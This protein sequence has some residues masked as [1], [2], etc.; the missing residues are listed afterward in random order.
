MGRE[1]T[2]EFTVLLR[3]SASGD[4]AARD[5]LWGQ[6]HGQLRDMARQRLAR[7]FGHGGCDATELVHEV[8]FK[9]EPLRIEPR[10]RLHFLALAARA[11][12]QVLVDQARARGSEKRGSGQ[13]AVTL[14]THHGGDQAAESLD[15]LDLETALKEL[16]RLDQRKAR[17]IEL[18]Y[19]A[20]LTDEEVAEALDV[21]SATIKRDLRIA[22]AWLA[23][24]LD[25]SD[26]Q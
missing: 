17:A 7:E 1:D 23:A 13:A 8:F 14:M 11:M 16:E 4:V 26:K 12:R 20:G 19:F 3:R 21:S 22:R 5:A 24:A 10:D 6:I 25:H 2:T 9:L 18:S 15:M